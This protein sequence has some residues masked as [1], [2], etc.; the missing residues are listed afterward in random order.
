MQTI[1]IVLNIGEGEVEAFERGFREMEAPIWADL[2][3]RGLLTMATL[4]KLD[5]T[6]KAVEGAAQYLVVAIFATD[7]GHHEHDNDPRF[8]AWNERADAYQVAEPFVFGGDTI[9]SQGP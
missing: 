9:V 6:T 7:E 8:K 3:A 1:G 4:T 2:H 5:I